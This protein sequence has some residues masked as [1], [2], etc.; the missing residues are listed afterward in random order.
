MW[1]NLHA[2]SKA[3]RTKSQKE[4][5]S[6]TETSPAE[7]VAAAGQMENFGNFSMLQQ[8]AAPPSMEQRTQA[9]CNQGFQGFGS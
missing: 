6:Q 2:G 1:K 9:M 8:M 4:F 3:F 5:A 7:K